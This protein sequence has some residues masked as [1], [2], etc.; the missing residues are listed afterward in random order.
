MK[1]LFIKLF[2]LLSCV[3]V[4]YVIHYTWLTKY[5]SQTNP[6]IYIYILVWIALA[7]ILYGIVT[8]F[9]TGWNDIERGILLIVYYFCVLWLLVIGRQNYG[10]TDFSWNPF[11]FVF[12][13]INNDFNSRTLAFQNVLLFIPAPII[14]QFF[15]KK[16]NTNVF[17]CA[18]IAISVEFIQR[19]TGRGIFDLSDIT[20]YFI[21][22]SIGFILVNPFNKLEKIKL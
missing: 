2:I 19:I 15:I 18:V 12:D 13:I 8:F 6:P 9:F 10:Y 22:I 11:S 3:V 7:I 20:L 21:G 14:N 5:I 17:L 1:N 16:R 4:A